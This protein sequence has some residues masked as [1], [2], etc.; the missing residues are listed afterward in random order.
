MQVLCDEIDED[1]FSAFFRDGFQANLSRQEEQQLAPRIAKFIG[2][3]KPVRRGGTIRLD[4]LPEAGTEVRIDDEL[5][6]V[7]PGRDFHQALLRV[8]LGARP[9]DTKLKRAVLGR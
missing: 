2:L 7:I 5:R 4:Y 1:D 9:A 6:G 8:W 3:F